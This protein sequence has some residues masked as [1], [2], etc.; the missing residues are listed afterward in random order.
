[1]ARNQALAGLAGYRNILIGD[2]AGRLVL[3]FG[4]HREA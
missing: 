2:R 4:L 3:H 1:M